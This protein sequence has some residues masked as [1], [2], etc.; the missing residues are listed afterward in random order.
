MISFGNCANL[1]SSNVFITAQAPTYPTG[2]T[3]GLVFTI[4][5]FCLACVGTF[6]LVA[7]NKARLN[8]RAH[9]SA[10]ETS[11]QDELSLKFH[12]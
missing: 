6:S 9:M 12:I 3:T 7:M 4:F 11:A 10:D 1:V 2:F 5:G 8:R